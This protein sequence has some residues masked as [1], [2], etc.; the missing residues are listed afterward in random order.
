LT[1]TLLLPALACAGELTETRITG[2][3][4]APSVVVRYG[5]LHLRTSVGVR[6]LHERLERAAWQVCQQ[7]LERPVSIEGN[8]CRAQ[9]VAAA[10]ADIN[11]AQL[12]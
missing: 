9:R 1:A 8:K 10:V 6:A 4:P 11:Q 12:A 2:A 5:D 3:S 7:M